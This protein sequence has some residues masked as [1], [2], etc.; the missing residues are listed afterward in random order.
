[1]RR[2]PSSPA[3]PCGCQAVPCGCCKPLIQDL[4]L[5]L[6]QTLTRIKGIHQSDVV[7]RSALEAA[8][9]DIRANPWLMDYI[10]ASLPQDN[11]TWRTYGEKSVQE[12]KKWFLNTNIPILVTP[13]LN[14]LRAPSIT[15]TLNAH[16][17]ISGRDSCQ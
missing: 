10:F 11:L 14:E 5:P 1:M 15:I 7:I 9:A 16:R 17:R 12:A 8:F 13:T 4:E 3:A 6:P 2:R